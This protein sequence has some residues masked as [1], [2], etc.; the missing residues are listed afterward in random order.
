M[1]KP[2]GGSVEPGHGVH[3]TLVGLPHVLFADNQLDSV[4]SLWLVQ[5]LVRVQ[6]NLRTAIRINKIFCNKFYV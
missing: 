5:P 6:G 1:H 4:P 2:A 3:G